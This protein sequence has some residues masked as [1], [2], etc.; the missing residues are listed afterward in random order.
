LTELVKIYQMAKRSDV[1]V[2]P[3][4]GTKVW[5]L[6]AIGPLDAKPLAGFITLPLALS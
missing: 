1:K 4:R 3:H 2:C 6:H 5:A